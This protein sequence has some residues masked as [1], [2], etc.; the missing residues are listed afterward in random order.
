MTGHAAFTL[1][2]LLLPGL[3][4]ARTS[5]HL[6][7]DADGVYWVALDGHVCAATA[8]GAPR[9]RVA[10]PGRLPRGPLSTGPSVLV[11]N[12]IVIHHL[13]HLMRISRGDGA[14]RWS[15]HVPTLGF[16]DLGA[17][18]VD[19]AGESHLVGGG[20]VGLDGP[21]FLATVDLGTGAIVHRGP[22]DDLERP[23][24]AIDDHAIMRSARGERVMSV[25]IADA[26]TAWTATM[27][28][29][30]QHP[31]FSIGQHT[32]ACARAGSTLIFG[33][34]GFGLV[35]I[36]AG[37]GGVRW[38]V[39]TGGNGLPRAS[40]DREQA[41]MFTSSLYLVFDPTT[42]DVLSRHEL[43]MRL[44]R[45]GIAKFD[46]FQRWRG[47]YFGVGDSGVAFA[48]DPTRADLA[49]KHQLDA[50]VSR[51]PWIAFDRLW[52]ADDDGGIHVFDLAGV[53]PL[54]RR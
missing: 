5:S 26:Q 39:L 41:E 4:T 1:P 38:E 2:R 23:L 49:W 14:L 30:S 28:R 12:D 9:W 40:V 15:L 50:R 44:V 8:E 34:S 19:A 27:T 3:A 25:R 32:G 45:Q 18:A 42:G 46:M 52:I 13:E 33:V 47:Y 7:F 54:A 11:G 16:R 35:G 6:T 48:F 21:Y 17:I 29:P 24:L 10:M 20:M 37:T 43:G 31:A 51:T 53:P 36:D 22:R